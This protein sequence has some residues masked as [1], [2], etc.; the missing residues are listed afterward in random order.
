M[1]Q[2]KKKRKEKR[3]REKEIENDYRIR[4][5]LNTLFGFERLLGYL[6][7]TGSLGQDE[8]AQS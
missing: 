6:S 4:S 7:D 2:K 5:I 3:E 8:R 1:I